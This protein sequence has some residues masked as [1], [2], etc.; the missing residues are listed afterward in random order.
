[1][2]EL[3]ALRA[4]IE[5]HPPCRIAE[6]HHKIR[7]DRQLPDPPTHPIGTKILSFHKHSLNLK[8]SVI[9]RKGAKNA[10][11]A[12]KIQRLAGSA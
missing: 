8:T 7:R 9:H 1:M 2:F 11:D 10:K 4:V 6:P 5:Q 3:L 12:K